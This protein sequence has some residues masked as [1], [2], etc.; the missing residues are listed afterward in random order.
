MGWN[1]WNV[2]KWVEMDWNVLEWSEIV[3]NGQEQ[4]ETGNYV[5]EYAGVGLNGL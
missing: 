1:G 3:W 4:A 5:L 2:L